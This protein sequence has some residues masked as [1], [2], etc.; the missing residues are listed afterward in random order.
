L[1][2]ARNMFATWLARACNML[3]TFLI[4][5]YDPTADGRAS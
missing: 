3:A 5:L 1:D 4:R 2:V